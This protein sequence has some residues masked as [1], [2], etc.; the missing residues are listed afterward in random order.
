MF[1]LKELW[2]FHLLILPTKFLYIGLTWFRMWATSCGVD[3]SHNTTLE[4][5]KLFLGN[6][7]FTD[8]SGEADI[9]SLLHLPETILLI[10]ILFSGSFKIAPKTLDT[11]NG[12]YDL[13]GC[14]LNASFDSSSRH[15]VCGIILRGQECI[16]DSH[17]IF[18]IDIWSDCSKCKY[19]TDVYL[20]NCV[21]VH[22]E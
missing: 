22:R 20:S 4:I 11:N 12:I 1:F 21:Y 14:I 7:L 2:H 18:T 5:F 6:E 13:F 15:A 16:V 17:H 10:Y 9:S 19:K 3:S 8:I